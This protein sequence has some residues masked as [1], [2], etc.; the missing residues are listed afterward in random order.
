MCLRLVS[1]LFI[2]ISLSLIGSSFG[3]GNYKW[4]QSFGG[5]VPSDAVIAGTD[6][7]GANI[8]AGRAKHEDD[9]LPAKINPSLGGA[10]VSKNGR[11][12]KKTEYEVLCSDDIAWKFCSGG[13]VPPEALVMGKTA[14]G[15]PLY[16]GRRLIDGTLTPGK[17]DPKNKWLYVPYNGTELKFYNYDVL[18]LLI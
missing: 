9:L 3:R 7:N 2:C 14:D 12:Y 6:H 1:T 8:Y 16:M 10:F 15:D 13:D 18:I 11:D 17:V 5:S 4:V